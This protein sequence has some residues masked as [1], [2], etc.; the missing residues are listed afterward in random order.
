[1]VGRRSALAVN[2]PLYPAD[3]RAF[4]EV[5]RMIGNFDAIGI[6]QAQDPPGNQGAIGM[7]PPE[8][9]GI[10]FKVF[11]TL[12][13]R[14]IQTGIAMLIYMTPQ[15]NVPL[16]PRAAGDEKVHTAVLYPGAGTGIFIVYIHEGL[17][18]GEVIAQADG[19]EGGFIANLLDAVI[20][21]P[22]G[23][24]AAPGFLKPMRKADRPYLQPGFP[25]KV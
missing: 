6:N 16:R 4:H 19:A 5:A 14:C 18:F 25:G 7:R 23:G 9:F 24:I 13:K 12:R 11:L 1:M 15:Q 10:L 8:A 2:E 3:C 17:Q 21:K 22:A 20:P